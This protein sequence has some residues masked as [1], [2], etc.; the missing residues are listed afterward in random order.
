MD[1]PEAYKAQIEKKIAEGGNG[2]VD[3]MVLTVVWANY[4]RLDQV[5]ANPLVKLGS[6]IRDNKVLT[7]IIMFLAYVLMVLIP[8]LLLKVLGFDPSKWLPSP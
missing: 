8:E 7:A 2:D 5:E 3:M 6:A 1:I 4:T